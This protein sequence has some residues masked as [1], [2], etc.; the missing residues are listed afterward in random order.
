M[1]LNLDQEQSEGLSLLKRQD[2]V[3]MSGCLDEPVLLRTPDMNLRDLSREALERSRVFV[4]EHHRRFREV[5][6]TGRAS[7]DD[8]SDPDVRNSQKPPE[9]RHED[10]VLKFIR[11]I[12]LNPFLKQKDYFSLLGINGG[13]GVKMKNEAVS[14]GFVEEFSVNPGGKGGSFKCL[15]VTEKG[16]A[17]ARLEGVIER[18][19][20]KGGREHVCLQHM[21]ARRLNSLGIEAV[22]EGDINGKNVDVKVYLRGKVHACEIELQITPQTLKNLLDDLEHGAEMVKV[23]VRSKREIYKLAEML[24]DHETKTSQALLGSVVTLEYISRYV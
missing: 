4:E 1:L 13:T 9:G 2:V 8:D 20:G 15:H 19:R 6:R 12:A 11:V 23:L 10:S 14:L 5:A 7:H 24:G 17:F 22:V 3:F 21:V 18:P 16:L